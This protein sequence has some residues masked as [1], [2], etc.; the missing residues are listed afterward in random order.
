MATISI[1]VGP[2]TVTRSVPDSKAQ[3]FLE[4]VSALTWHNLDAPDPTPKQRLEAL[5]DDVIQ[6]WFRLVQEADRDVEQGEMRSRLASKAAERSA[7][8]GEWLGEVE[9]KAERG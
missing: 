2:I 8:L 6:Y 9:P 1:T 5:L 3:P 4:E 7:A